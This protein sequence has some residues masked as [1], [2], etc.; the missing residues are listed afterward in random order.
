MFKKIL[1]ILINKYFVVTVAFIVWMGFF[2]IDNFIARGKLNDKLTTLKKEKQFFLNEIRNDSILTVRLQT[3][4]L[5]LEQ[6]AREKYQMKKEKEDVY[7][8]FDTI[9]DRHP[10]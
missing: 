1:R 5:A 2:D 6:L 8:I 4:S 3:D 10:Q 7:L 9:A